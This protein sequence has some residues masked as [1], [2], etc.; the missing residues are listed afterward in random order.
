MPHLRHGASADRRYGEADDRELRYLTRRFWIGAVLTAPLVLL[1]MAPMVGY[2]EPFG[3]SPRP[4]GWVEFAVGTP[5][6]LWVGWPILHKFWMSLVNRAWNMYTLIGLG[7]GL[8]SSTASRPY[9]CLVSFRTNS[10]H[11]TA[12]SG[13]IS[14]PQQ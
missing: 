13:R 11:T 10:G 7:V 14:R 1:A 8:A 3:L 2:G 5:V 4:R 9:L 6:V 12:Q